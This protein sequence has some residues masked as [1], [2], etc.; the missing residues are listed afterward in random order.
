MN[1]GNRVLYVTSPGGVLHDVMAVA[2]AWQRPER[3][4]AVDA[5]QTRDVLAG[6]DVRWAADLEPDQRSAVLAEL[7]R[8]VVDLST[9]RPRWLVSAGTGLAVPWFLAARTL[10]VPTVWIE[11]LNMRGETGTAAKFCGR[12]ATHVLVQH[13][14]MLRAGSRRVLVGELY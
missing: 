5:P 10:R 14:S 4:V 7:L 2:N 3:W 9:R 13:A 11:T 1:A 8:A 6:R 12:L